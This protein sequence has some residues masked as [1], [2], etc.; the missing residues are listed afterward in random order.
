MDVDAAIFDMDGVIVDSER[1]WVQEQRT[2]LATAVP[3]AD[4]APGDL[5]GMNVMDQY[6]YLADRFDV[7]VSKEE[8]FDLYDEKAAAVYTDKAALMEG[9]TDLLA[10][11]RDRGVKTAIASSSFRHWI[12]L[13]LDRF[14][15]AEHFEVVVSAEDIDGRSKPAPDIY[16]HAAHELGVAPERCVVVEDSGHGIEAANAAAMYCIGYNVDE[17]QDLSHAD[18]VVAGPAALR[19]ALEKLL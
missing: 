4:V 18:V 2:I 12:R 15:L 9:F 7:A 17:E 3:D 1:Y 5:R 14:D 10:T 11:I 16:L 8:Y 19:D 6:D 13:M